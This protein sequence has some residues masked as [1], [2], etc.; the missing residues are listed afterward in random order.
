MIDLLERK[1]GIFPIIDCR[2]AASLE[3]LIPKISGRA[4]MP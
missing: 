4:I 2:A 3:G 1:A